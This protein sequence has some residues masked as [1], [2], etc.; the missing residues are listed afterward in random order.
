M[1]TVA[2]EVRAEKCAPPAPVAPPARRGTCNIRLF[3]NGSVYRI[4]RHPSGPFARVWH[5]TKLTGTRA[6]AEHLTGRVL[7]TN[8]C[9]CDDMYHRKPKGGCKHIKAL[10]ALGLISGRYRRSRAASGQE[11]GRS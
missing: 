10:V 3:I 9:S 4:R 1:S 8:S 6:G 5:L 2:P 7:C 11:G